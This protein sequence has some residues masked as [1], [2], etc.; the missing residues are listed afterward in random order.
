MDVVEKDVL[1]K[2][3][4]VS[5][6]FGSVTALLDVSFEVYEN[7][8]V[9]LVGDNG[10]GKSTLI[11][12][13]SGNFPP[14]SGN[15]YFMGKKIR[16]SNPSDARKVGI[17]TVYQDLSICNNLDAASNLFI[18]R[19]IYKN[20]LGLGIL[21]IAEMRRQTQEILSKVDIKIPSI[22]EK[23][24]YLSGG[25]R[26]AVSLGRFI[27]W[28]KKLILLDEPTAALGVRETGKV[29]DLIKRTKEERKE[30]S[31]ILISH[32]MQQIFE[33]VDRIIVL[34]HGEIIGIR[35]TVETN[36]DEIVSLITGAIFVNN[37]KKE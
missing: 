30:A 27:A 24:L 32:N 28:G 14:D 5:K 31:I 18:G 19:E 1:L 16:F 20:V 7:E 17:E 8:I 3:D 37:K 35:K 36:T 10:A 26:Q 23:V 15:I 33:I 29:L 6:Y 25:Q 21:N 34:R 4:K 11:K 12:I 9:G 13:L 2:V 22:D